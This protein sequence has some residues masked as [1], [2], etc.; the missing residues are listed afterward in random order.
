MLNKLLL[1]LLVYS[2]ELLLYTFTFVTMH[3]KTIDEPGV[4]ETY[5]YS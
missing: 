2:Y 5:N 4:T 3:N 1:L